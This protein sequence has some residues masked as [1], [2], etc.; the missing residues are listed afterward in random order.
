MSGISL[1]KPLVISKASALDTGPFAD[2]GEVRHFSAS[3]SMDATAVANPTR[4]LAQR[5]NLIADKLNEV[6]TMVNNKEQ[7]VNLPV[8]RTV[9]SPGSSE[10]VTNYRIPAGFE[11]RI[12]NAKVSS[13]PIG[14]AKLDIY[15][16]ADSFGASSGTQV[17]TTAD[18]L[19]GGTTFWPSGEFIVAI[20]NSGTATAE[21]FA[22]IILTMRPVGPQAGGLIGPGAEGAR[23][24]K[25][26]PGDQGQ[27]GNPGPTGPRGTPGL[28][29][30]GLWTGVT[31]YVAGDV[32]RYNFAGTSGYSSYVARTTSINQPPPLPAN[33]LNTYWELVAQAATG[34][35]GG[36][37]NSG[38]TGPAGAS[39]L[40]AGAWNGT[41]TYIP[42]NV[43]RYDF[44]GTIGSA[45]FIAKGTNTNHAPPAAGVTSNAYWDLMAQGGSG[46]QGV[47]GPVGIDYVG[48]WQTGTAYS[49]RA[50]VTIPF[51]GSMY[52]T[53]YAGTNISANIYPSSP[54]GTGWIQFYG[55]TPNSGIVSSTYFATGTLVR[56]TPF[57]EGGTSEGIFDPAPV[58]SLISTAVIPLAE[59]YSDP[60]GALL[61]QGVFYT[62]FAGSVTLNLPQTYNNSRKNWDPASTTII[63]TIHSDNAPDIIRPTRN[64]I[65]ISGTV[66]QNVAIN[67]IGIKSNTDI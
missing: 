26:D 21:I 35:T 66:P 11:A 50:L 30:K 27:Q 54:S 55:P 51:S 38:P 39:I 36:S 19:S 63:T 24:P 59:T 53:Y 22:S 17:V 31:T 43:V 18:E 23:G 12:F 56:G 49:Q 15:H 28:V 2:T 61:L 6:I 33:Q 34:Q 57:Y 25:G 13:S 62:R 37:G 3:D 7:Y 45:A 52:K 67:I 64:S 32:V 14:S 48:P 41:T 4:Q 8:F 10:I 46:P 58:T 20:F 44:G 40:W 65:F 1:I 5:D 29:W 16:N 60:G 47:Q 42:Q 9:L